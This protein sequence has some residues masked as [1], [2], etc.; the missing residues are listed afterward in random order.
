[1]SLV[2]SRVCCGAIERSD[3][4]L[5]RSDTD[6]D[7]VGPVRGRGNFLDNMHIRSLK[8]APPPDSRGHAFGLYAPLAET[9]KTYASGTLLIW[10][11]LCPPNS[12]N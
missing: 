5:S 9:S 10:R 1:M 6:A 12:N 8:E 7:P 4:S 11:K 3:R 2:Y